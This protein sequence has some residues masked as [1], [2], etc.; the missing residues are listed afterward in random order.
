MIDDLGDR[1][2]TTKEYKEKCLNIKQFFKYQ[3]IK[4][5]TCICNNFLITTTLSATTASGKEKV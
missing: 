3:V 5:I 1:S 4:K 2:V